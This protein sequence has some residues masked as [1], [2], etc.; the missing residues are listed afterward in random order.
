MIKMIVVPMV[1]FSITAGVASLG[2]LKKLRNIGVKVVGL[3]ALTSALCVGLGLIMANIINPG[4]G[5]DLTALSQ[6]TDYEAQAMPSIIDTLID[7]FPSNIFTSFTNTNMLQIIVF[8]VFLGVALI[9]MGK[10]GERLLAGVQ[11]CANAMYKITAIVME[12]SPIGVC[13]LLADSVGA[14]GLKI[15]GPLGKLILTVYASDVILVLLM[16][17]PM[18]AFLA[19][20]PVKKWLQGIWKVWVVTASTTSSSGSLPITTS[21][22]NDEF[23]VSSELSSFSLPLGATINMNGGCIYYAAAIVMTAQI[24]GMNLTPSA[25]VNIIISTVLVAMGC[26][27]VPGGAIIMT[28]ILLTNMG[29]PLEIVGLIAGI[30]RLIDMA[31][32][33]FNVTG[34]VVTTMVVAR[35]EGMMHTLGTGAETETKAA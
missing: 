12:F 28:T 23:G 27:G 9:M 21:V 15:F 26:P 19:K 20:F 6:S 16:Y 3:Y 31:N 34:D 2:D 33:T 10:E 30:F 8:S 18:V 24:Y 22:T 32:T 4:K 25:L 14:Y 1:F 35:S 29:L 17:I 7:M 13:A 5:F 11:G